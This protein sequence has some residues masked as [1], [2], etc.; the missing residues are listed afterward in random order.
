[1]K[2]LAA[3]AAILSLLSGCSL[4]KSHDIE[5]Q[6]NPLAP[7]IDKDR[8][9]KAT[10]AGGCFWCIE[11]A[12]HGL[13]GV[14][15]VISGYT[16]G[17]VK[18]P[19][20]EQVSTGTTGH[21]EAIQVSY[22]PSLISYEELVEFFWRQFD[23]TDAGGSFHD[24][25]PQYK[26]AI[27]YANESQKRIA[28][29]SKQRLT[30][31]RIFDKPVVTQILKLDEFYP[32]EEYHQQYCVKNPARYIS[33]RSASGRDEFITSVWGA[34]GV[35]EYSKPSPAELNARLTDLQR[36]VTQHNGTE[37]AFANEYWNNHEEGIYV[38]VTTG[39]P[40]FSSRDKFDSGTGWP[41]FTKP[42]D[43][44]HVAKRVDNTHAMQ[45]IEVRSRVGD[46]HLGHLFEDGPAPSNLRY[47]MNSASLQFEP[48]S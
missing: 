17:H 28:E 46:A 22:D 34:E 30:S 4:M 8:L 19:S 38:D 40:L 45:R 14:D 10:F 37:R 27:F 29:T 35:H 5:Q 7:V 9:E 31:A 42:I 39:E 3:V 20:Y 24:R 48:R 16:G 43:P 44:R 47:C 26:S 13:D 2:T 15:T 32:A 33:Y 36:T 6:G 23:P 21:Y 12:F 1:M 18:N 25:G 41:S 11:E